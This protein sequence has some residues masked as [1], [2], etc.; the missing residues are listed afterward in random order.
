[1]NVSMT[2]IWL[3]ISMYIFETIKETNLKFWDHKT[4]LFIIYTKI[5]IFILWLFAKKK[6]MF[7]HD[8]HDSKNLKFTFCILFF[9]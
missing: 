3:N 9:S 2:G 8:Q 4:L 1:M 6:Q 7:H 5:C